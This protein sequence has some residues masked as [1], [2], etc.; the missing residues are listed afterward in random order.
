MKQ[1]AQRLGRILNSTLLS[2]TSRRRPIRHGFAAL[3]GVAAI[4][5]MSMS[6]RGSLLL[7]EDFNYTAG[8]LLNANGWSTITS[9]AGATP[10]AIAAPGLT[11]AGYAGSGIGNAVS[12]GTSGEDDR[13]TFTSQASGSVYA[14]ML[15]NV[16]SSQTAGDYFF[17][18]TASGAAPGFFARIF[19]KKDATTSTFGLGIAKDTAGT[20]AGPSY[21]ATT[22]Y[23]LN[24]TYLVV[25][26]YTFNTGTTTDDRIDLFVNPALGVGEPAPTIA[27]VTSTGT[28]S[29][30]LAQ[31]VLRQGSA[32]SAAA[33]A[34]DGIRVAT[35]WAEAAA[36]SCTPPTA[37]VSGSATI[38][39]GNS[40]TIQAALTG[41]GPWNVTWSDSLIQTG[42]AASPATRSV[43]PTATTSY[44]VTAVS[45]STGCT[46]GTFS[47]TAT[48]TV[49]PLPAT[50]AITGS[51][52]VCA[53]SSGVHYSVTPTTG[54]S[55]AWTVP[56]GAS[57]TSGA[58]GPNNNEIVV[59][60]GST[61]GNVT[62][63]ETSTASCVGSPVSTSVAVNP[64][65]ATSSITGPA[66][67]CSGASGVHYSVTLTSGSSYAWTVPS[68]A[69]I[70]SGG[71]GPNNNEIVVA[72]GTSGGAV[73]VTE[74]TAAGC[75]GSLVSE[76]S[77]VNPV[78]ATSAIT[79]SSTVAQN[80]AGVHYSVTL[81]SGSSYVW[82]VPGGASITSGAT[83]PDNNEIIVTFGISSGNVTV[84]ETS[85]AGCV[86]SLQTLAIGVEGPPTITSQPADQTVCSGNAAVFA[87]SASGAGTVVYQWRRDGTNLINGDNISGADTATL[88]INPAGPADA[89]L[90]ANG[91]DCDVTNEYGSTLTSPRVVL[92][93]NPLPG[94]HNTTGG[95]GY[96]A[97]GAGVSVGLDGSASGVTY[98]LKRGAVAVTSLPG[99]GSALDFGLQTVAGTYSVVATNDTT[100]C[101]VA[102]VGSATVTVNPVPSTSAISGSAV[103]CTN[104]AGVAYSVT[105][106]SGSSYVWT[107]P[108]GASI[109]AGATG[110][111]NNQI[112]VTFGTASGNV[113]VTETSAAGCVGSPISLAVT[114]GGAISV[115]AQPAN[116]VTVPASTAQF[117]VTASDV[118][119]YQWEENSGN[120]WSNVSGGSGANTATY[121]TPALV[122]GDNGKQYRCQLSNGCG[123]V[124]SDPA[125]L[126][127]AAYVRSKTSGNWS[128]TA[129]W[130][131]STDGVTYNAA[132][133]LS[134]SA[135]NSD[136]IRIQGTH[137]VTVTAAASADQLTVDPNGQITIAAS[138]ALTIANGTGTD[139]SNSGAIDVAGTLTISSGAAVVVNSG[140][141]LKKNDGGTITTT[142]SLTFN[143]G[144]KYQHN[145]TTSAGSIPTSTWNTGSTCEIIGYTTVTSNPAGLGQAFYNFTWNCSSQVNSINLAD[146][147]TNILGDFTVL[148]TGTGGTLR[149]AGTTVSS[150]M[151][152]SGN[153]NV[154]GGALVGANNTGVL[155]INLAGNLNV[156]GGSFD[157][158]NSTGATG[159]GCTLNLSGNLAVG[160]GATLTGT[161]GTRQIIFVGTGIQAYSNA[162]TVS[163]NIGWTVNSG[164]TVDLGTSVVA[165]TAATF[166]VN[167]GGGLKTAHANGFNGNLTVTGAKSLNTAGNYTY[168]GTVAQV[169][170]SQLPATVNSL[171]IANTAA[172][173]QLSQDL[174]AVN[175]TLTVIPGATLDF[176]G[177]AVTLA[178]APALNGALV[179]EVNKTA[180]NTFS[181][182]KLTQ[183]AG[184]LAYGGTLT[185]S[186]S[187]SALAGGD[188][189]PL[190]VSGASLY[191]GGFSAVTGP[192]VPSGLARSVAQL[193]GGTGGNVLI[194]CDGTLAAS[195]GSARTVCAGTGAAI[196]GSPTVT[197]GAAPYTYA[198]TPATGL[199][200]ATLA[201]PTAAPAA[202]T[203]YTLLATDANGC[204]AGAAVTV[205]VNPAATVNAGPDQTICAGDAAALAGSL[206]GSAASATW[207]GAG[208]FSPSATTLTATYTPTPAEVSAGTATLTLTTD[209]PD[210]V[211]PCSA[212]V[213]QVVITIN[214]KPAISLQPANQSVCASLPAV[215]TVGA[216]GTSLTY[217]WQLSGDAGVTFT[218]IGDAATYAAYTNLVSASANNG[219]QYRVIVTGTCGSVTSAPPAILTVTVPEL[220]IVQQG[221]S[222]VVSWPAAC[223]TYLLE[224]KG[225]VESLTAWTP[226]T[227]TVIP[228]GGL[229]TVTVAVGS[230]NQFFRLRLP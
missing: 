19:V 43:S 149:L 156:S 84:Q 167:S 148:T 5:M 199:N 204:T 127:V 91:Y 4:A 185:V 212:A 140:G 202:T 103:A 131:W 71:T 198:W 121:T 145:L 92:M 153:L 55:Y 186:A 95:G 99:S 79:G 93:V 177:K 51:A 102:M 224:A 172:A 39:R 189:I 218:N 54:S 69:N 139:L 175:G 205:T 179:M 46:P 124:T 13:K 182:S 35:T 170:G 154:Q 229:N 115:S 25:V 210:G 162:G 36:A 133:A 120:G 147:L 143:S 107:V 165:G 178:S 23:N 190:F 180:P 216:T 68:G 88:T 58:T 32:A 6:A 226:V 14:A 168:N 53:G 164:S 28:D 34:V 183:S 197:G 213:D 105:L 89:V 144:A 159:G 81:T 228:V 223:V 17:S 1:L 211:G 206:G 137:I 77:T 157:L 138:Q 90:L 82:T 3:L 40:T 109:T 126:T 129:T 15:I 122:A 98:T 160:A 195:A 65:P 97:G 225:E 230:T 75:V 30:G 188:S 119:S 76:S 31:V 94:S 135:A 16:S 85:T 38:C 61:E 100:F 104:A 96:C 33:L 123:T 128:D 47:G 45:D 111:D 73:T 118:A 134:P 215:F 24:Q 72:F 146:N 219:N 125:S 208:A 26:K 86:G 169:T 10:P 22:L 171:T 83:G 130:E 60:F 20:T 166:T 52:A 200:D 37:A 8:T 74:T 101:S 142:G 108:S 62:V 63:T 201:N 67:V 184:T 176:N 66:S 155:V 203:T 207:S 44:T 141:I 41:T 161:S 112:A 87:V 21:T 194:T 174:V 106:T 173:V 220:S 48:V 193:T 209:D 42:V 50:S 181:G 56:S 114:V 117:S 151:S 113:T 150:P 132:V 80:Q 27:N 221:A 214:T 2:A 152:I 163:G 49:N 59:A 78:P 57:I 191:S 110:P 196:G 64:L 192:A 18:L 187:G 227:E 158:K 217:Q 70:S 29:T 116:V 136:S 12:M 11:Y 222:V 9:G 7:T